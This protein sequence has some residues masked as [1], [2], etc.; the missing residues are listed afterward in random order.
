MFDFSKKKTKSSPHLYLLV[1]VAL[2]SGACESGNI[3]V[4][5]KNVEEAFLSK[6]FSSI[7]VR[8]GESRNVH[9]TLENEYDEEH[10]II[11]APVVCRPE[12][13]ACQLP[14]LTVHH[15]VYLP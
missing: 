4:V 2:R 10:L 8:Y 12:G 6:S 14:E 15:G 11:P 7:V 9:V 13:C 1:L 5:R 3:E